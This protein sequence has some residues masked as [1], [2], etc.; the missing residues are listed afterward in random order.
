MRINENPFVQLGVTPENSIAEIDEA[1]DDKCFEDE[2]RENIY[3]AAR[4]LL[5]NPRKRII[6][7]VRWFFEKN[8][9]I[10]TDIETLYNFNTAELPSKISETIQYIDEVYTK[11]SDN[12]VPTD[13]LNEINENR[14]KAGI[15]LINDEELV[16]DTLQD[17]V[18]EDFKG[19]INELLSHLSF[20]VVVEIANQIALKV[21]QPSI[22]KFPK[23]YDEIV[24]VFIDSYYG[25]V[26]ETLERDAQN[27]LRQIEQSK[28]LQKVEELQ[29]LFVK[30]REFDSLA[31]PLQLYFQD[32][33]QADKQAE[34][35]QIAGALRTLALYYYNEKNA[36]ALSLAITEECLSIFAENSELVQVFQK[37]K[38]FLQ[39]ETSKDSIQGKILNVI[40]QIDQKIVRKKGYESNNKEQFRIHK[41]EWIKSLRAIAE[42]IIN[43]G[44][45]NNESDYEALALAY[46]CLASACTWANLWDYA[47]FI[48]REGLSYVEKSGNEDFISRYKASLSSWAES[49]AVKKVLRSNCFTIEQL[50][51]FKKGESSIGRL[52]MIILIVFII[53]IIAL[54]F[55]ECGNSNKQKQ[56]TYRKSATTTI[57]NQNAKNSEEKI[58]YKEPSVGNSRVLNL[59]E[60][61]W[62]AREKIRLD[63]MKSLV[64]NDEGINEL[65][66]RIDYYNARG[67]SFQY[68]GNSWEKARKDVEKHRVQIEKEVEKEV[69]DKGWRNEISKINTAIPVSPTITPQ[70]TFNY[71]HRRIT[72][73]NFEAAYR[74]LSP[75]MK[76]F[77]GNMSTWASG[78]DNTISSVPMQVRLIEQT[79]TNAKI[80]FLLKAVD[81]KDG[82]VVTRYFQGTCSMI[83]YDGSWKIDEVQGEWQ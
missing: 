71:Y 10:F 79:D 9:H 11:I 21:I 36:P 58:Q 15:P 55:T 27:L 31:Q 51:E 7:E 47:Y 34:S 70:M 17:A 80:A 24:S 77:V 72:E 81:W 25:I 20:T 28:S 43:S 82:Y 48:L 62:V 56:G 76:A 57:S 44:G 59:D 4:N 37:D 68:M 12:P 32:K 30:L 6:A 50:E 46:S 16:M 78:Y 40:E 67:G 83:L 52:K 38:V 49:A 23:L 33:G 29:S 74:Y 1:K 42:A 5:L 65:N 73:K 35:Q 66:R 2:S 41:D 61:H 18:I 26:R 53:G 60:M 14:K 75:G 69:E 19:G 54:L 63:K 45:N 8:N 39:Q 3:E 22:G 64:V 13:L